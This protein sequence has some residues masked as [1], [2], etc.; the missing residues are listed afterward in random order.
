MSKIGVLIAGLEEFKC[1]HGLAGP[2]GDEGFSLFKLYPP[3]NVYIPPRQN[4][5]MAKVALVRQE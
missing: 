3:S 2:W 1:R 5:T 4:G